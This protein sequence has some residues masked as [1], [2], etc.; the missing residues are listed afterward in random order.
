[1]V[2]GR[3]SITEMEK[4][5]DAIAGVREAHVE[6][7]GQ[8]DTLIVID[9]ED[10]LIN[11]IDEMVLDNMAAGCTAPGARGEH[12]IWCEQFRDRRLLG[13]S[14]LGSKPAVCRVDSRSAVYLS[15]S[16]TGLPRTA[17]S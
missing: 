1:M 13:G 15:R 7:L 16:L 11:D 17:L 9:A 14:G 12:S 4:H 2:N 10:E 5:I 8:G 3:A 6:S